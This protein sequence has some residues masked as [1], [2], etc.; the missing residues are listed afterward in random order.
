VRQGGLEYRLD[1]LR[2]EDLEELPETCSLDVADRGP[3][4]LEEIARLY[5]VTRERIRQI[6][7]KALERLRKRLERARITEEMAAELGRPAASMLGQAQA[8]DGGGGALPKG[9]QLP[10][11]IPRG[12]RAP[13]VSPGQPTTRPARAPAEETMARKSILEEL[14]GKA[15]KLVERALAGELGPTALHEALAEAG[16]EDLPTRRGVQQWLARRTKKAARKPRRKAA[17]GSKVEEPQEQPAP[18]ALVARPREGFVVTPQGNILA[19]TAQAAVE[20]A[21]LL[22]GGR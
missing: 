5:G 6:E 20:V 10:E 11:D 7:E 4:T 17:P 9:Y 14:T 22:G 15:G 19:P 8:V 16:V 21:R 2:A 1:L 18:V 13:Y 12:P 3:H